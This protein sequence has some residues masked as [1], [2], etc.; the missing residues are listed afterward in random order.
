MDGGDGA[1]SPEKGEETQRVNAL[2]EEST[3]SEGS[4]EVAVPDSVPLSP[5][6]AAP[7]APAESTRKV[8]ESI[9]TAVNLK[10]EGAGLF[11]S[12]NYSS[13]REKYIAALESLQY[14]GEHLTDAQK[15]ALFELTI[16]LSSNA[17]LCFFKEENYSEC[18]TFTKN[19]LSFIGVLEDLTSSTIK[20]IWP[21][22][23]SRGILT[24]Q[25][26]KELKKKSLALS[27]KCHCFRQNYS[28][29]RQLLSKALS[30]IPEADR[31]G[32][33]GMELQRWLDRVSAEENKA[34]KREKAIWSKAFRRDSG[35]SSPSNGA[36]GKGKPNNGFTAFGS[37]SKSWN[38]GLILGA[39]G[40][41]GVLGISAFYFLRNRKA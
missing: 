10:N 36:P 8:D 39:V 18:L 3:K 21:T 23:V 13:A 7:E 2:A 12:Q 17:A 33:E 27:G 16:P 6:A 5:D 19:A 38:Y 15:A 41:A 26:L 25:K 34:A 31:G 28:E 24:Q 30:L 32:K 22:I 14:V 20:E 29:A 40:V 4:P 9:Q 35:D 37:R 11:S 1:L